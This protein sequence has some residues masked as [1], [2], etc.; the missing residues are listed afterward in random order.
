MQSRTNSLPGELIDSVL[1]K[2]G[3]S[4]RP[5]ANL[6]GLRAVYSAWCRRVP[7]DNIR[8]MI[9]VR[10]RDPGRLPG[11]DAADFFDHWIRWGAGGTCWAGNGALCALLESL[12]FDARRA[13]ATMRVAPDVPPNHGSVTVQCEG[14]RYLVDA[15][16]LHDEPLALDESLTPG[17]GVATA[18][19][20]RAWAV[21]RSIHE[22]HW[23]ICWRPLH[24]PDALDCRIDRFDVTA[25]DFHF[26]H[27]QSRG[28]S[29]FNF[30]L[31]MRL[32]REDSVIGAAFGQRVLIDGMGHFEERPLHGADR[33]R[34]L[35]EEMGIHEELAR[36]L[37]ADVPMPPPPQ[38]RT[39][40]GVSV[41]SPP[42]PEV[43]G[44]DGGTAFIELR[45]RLLRES[46][47]YAQALRSFHWPGVSH[48]NWA[49]QYF[50]RMARDNEAP[51]L[52]V[53]DDS[54]GDLTLSFAALAHRSN[55]V[56]NFLAAAGVGP[57]DRVLIML[58]NVV[59]LWE[60][61]L[62][63][64]KLGAVL[65]PATTLLRRTDI[66]DRLARGQVRAVV[67]DRALAQH[68]DGLPGAPI[69][70]S[71]G[72]EAPGFIDFRNSH[73]ADATFR[74]LAPT[75]AEALMLLY[76]TSGTTAKPKLVAHSQ[77]S[78]AVGHLSTAYWIG[79]RR[80]DVHLNL[81]SPGWAKHAWSCFFAPWNAEATV[82]A[83]H[84]E[85]FNA[86]ALLDQ[87]VRCQVTTFCAPPT[88]WRMLIQEDLR[89]W[90]VVLRE[91]VGAGEPLNPEIIEQVR[92][93]WG[94]TIRDGFGQTET[95]ALI[96]NPP[97]ERLKPGSMG[98]PL[99]GY[100]VAL[101]AA[102]GAVGE[103]GEICLDLHRRPVGL[104]QAYLDDPEKT[105]EVMRDGYYHTG[106]VA[107]RD[108]DGY[109]TYVGRLDDV[110]KSSDYRISPF[111]LESVLIEHPLVAEAAVVPSPDPLRLAVPK[112][113]VVLTSGA[114]ADAATARSILDHVRGRVAP[115]KRI[116]CVEFAPLPKTISGKIRRIE[117]RL[118]E[119]DRAAE[120]ARRPG[121][122]WEEDFPDLLRRG[123]GSGETA[124]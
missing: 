106:D 16:I 98:R 91:V 11:D 12:G 21:A 85:R 48:F 57:G 19:A 72:G 49:Q 41:E 99:P 67:V 20:G 71:V 118:S 81:S 7:F 117:L 120:G 80:G 114:A 110:F 64:I 52:R 46:L 28:W 94:L 68:F 3:L 53:V 44:V 103:E 90:P 122:F 22:G 115:F 76:F 78:Y 25:A 87:L 93:A 86:V 82:L 95:T 112:A 97:G 109:L 75:P 43:A 65:I 100:D 9:H 36:A 33:M 1:A 8:K 108:A 69:R 119:N 47:P 14:R 4:G 40:Q 101:I 84:Y 27:E 63:A 15:S 55:Q 42:Q 83:Y 35:V 17:E 70:I 45:D 50:D 30:G 124:P 123:G 92:A 79:L 6:D 38:S 60:T 2:L 66:E 51:A 37:P 5:A 56:A 121:E 105:T 59:A 62:A 29:P 89:R 34:F 10:R 31:C 18:G 102:D 73:D 77:I 107:S 13:L 104:M 23:I 96:G 24:R 74:A 54:G 26:L 88:V 58:G 39:A 32:N 113:Y 111:E 116:R 61:M